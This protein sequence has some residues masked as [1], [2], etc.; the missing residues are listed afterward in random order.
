[1]DFQE[2]IKAR[3][4]RRQFLARMSAAGLGAAALALLSSATA[5]AKS[6]KTTAG[7][8][9]AKPQGVEGSAAAAFPGIPGSSNNEIVLNFALTLEYLEA[10][11]YRQAINRAT[12]RSLQTALSPNAAVYTQVAADGAFRCDV[13]ANAAFLYLKQFTYVEAAHRDFLI[14]AI[15]ASGGT[16]TAPNPNG[17]KFPNGLPGDLKGILQAIIPLEETGVRAYLGAAPYLTDL[18]SIQAASTIYSTEARH[19]AAINLVLNLPIG[20]VKMAGDLE[21]QP[22][23]HSEQTFEKYLTPATVI[24]AAGAYFV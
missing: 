1:M 3:P 2:I 16:P 15:Q 11:L 18:G 19:S 17:Y 5:E 22:N 23:P 8:R 21:V 12:G 24:A 14:A 9:T 10:D 13:E 7:R 4:A 6:G 20:P